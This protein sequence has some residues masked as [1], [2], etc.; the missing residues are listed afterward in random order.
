MKC[1]NCNEL[2]GLR[3]Q[4]RDCDAIAEREPK[5]DR[6]VEELTSQAKE[7]VRGRGWAR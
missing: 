7:R 5:L 3:L 1:P 6:R 4:V 2:K